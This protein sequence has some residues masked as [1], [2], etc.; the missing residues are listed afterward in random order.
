MNA[1]ISINAYTHAIGPF[2]MKDPEIPVNVKLVED[3]VVR[4]PDTEISLQMLK[5]LDRLKEDNDSAGGIVRC[6][7]GNMPVGLGEPVF[8]KLEAD[9]ARAMLS[10]GASKGFEIGS[11]F[12]AA[13]MLGSQHNDQYVVENDVVK[14]LSNHAGGVQGGISTG[15]DIDFKV[16]F[17]PVSSIGKA[18]RTVNKD[19][20]EIDIVVEG[21]HDVCIVPRA[22]PVV[23]AMT[24][25]VLA[26]HFLR[27]KMY[28]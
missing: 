4:C 19:N 28:G 22:V 3:S 25:L 11:G 13:H 1:G 6:I 12:E 7:V 27:L 20:K 23:E 17:K 9:L 21:R 5:Y 26:D 16:A 24:A 15:S 14:T 8:D 2:S 18:Q 10:I